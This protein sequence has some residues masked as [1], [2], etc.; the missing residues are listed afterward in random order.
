MCDR[1]KHIIIVVAN[2][3]GRPGRCT[4]V[5][6]A[7]LCCRGLTASRHLYSALVVITC[8]MHPPINHLE[9]AFPIARHFPAVEHS[10]AKRHVGAVTD[11]F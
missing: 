2:V 7:W 10:T 3:F 6:I 11:C 8:L 9:R 4:D 1:S 5:Y